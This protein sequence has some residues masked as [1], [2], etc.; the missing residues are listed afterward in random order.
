M[1]LIGVIGAMG[2][3]IEI[4]LRKSKIKRKTVIAGMMFIECAIEDVNCI[5]VVS[6]IGKVNAAVCTQILISNFSVSKIINT[7]VAG[8]IDSMLDIGDIVISSELIEYD[9]DVTVFGYK[10]GVIPRMK[11]SIFK[12]EPRLIDYALTA[13]KKNQDI[14]SYVGRI[15]SGDKFVANK[16]EV[17]SLKKEFNGL[18][19]EM[20]GAAIAHTCYLNKVPFVI[21]RAI[22][23]RADGKANISYNQFVHSSAKT[24]SNII[25][26]MIGNL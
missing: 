18:A 14:N 15:I 23:D 26:D 19:V 22:S 6:G 13:C 2:E 10:R 4:L 16:D 7:G 8:A 1:V 12:A 9:V 20:E 24:A 25:L 5:L 11:T 17:I 21:I 3:E